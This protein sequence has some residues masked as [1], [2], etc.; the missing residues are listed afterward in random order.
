MQY[1]TDQKPT[2][3]YGYYSQWLTAHGWPVRVQ[4]S[5]KQ[6]VAVSAQQANRHLLI[7]AS[8]NGGSTFVIINYGQLP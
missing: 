4:V 3:V 2:D 6:T 7:T 5:N 1:R 8:P